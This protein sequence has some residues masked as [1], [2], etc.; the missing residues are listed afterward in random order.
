LFNTSDDAIVIAVG[1][2]KQFFEF[3]IAIGMTFEEKYK[4]NHDRVRLRSELVPKIEKNLSRNNRDY[5]IRILNERNIPCGKVNDI[6]QAFGEPQVQDRSMIWNVDINGK[7]FPTIGN[8]L[9]FSETKIEENSHMP[10]PQLGQHTQE[11]L[12]EILGLS[13]RTIR[14]LKSIEVI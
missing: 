12:T 9:R 5:W 10:P 14:E 6:K 4:T 8:P 13:E 11:V 7:D 3:C 1:N 2:D